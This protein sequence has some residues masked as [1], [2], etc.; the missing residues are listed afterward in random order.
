MEESKIQQF[1]S[2]SLDVINGELKLSD[3]GGDDDGPLIE[4]TPHR[5]ARR[6]CELINDELCLTD[7]ESS[8]LSEFSESFTNFY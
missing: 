3:N 5:R 1:D 2:C 7:G 8:C 6:R 4:E